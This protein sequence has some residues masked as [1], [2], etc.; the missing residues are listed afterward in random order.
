MEKLYKKST[1]FAPFVDALSDV[2][3][4]VPEQNKGRVIGILE[5]GSGTGGLTSKLLDQLK[6]MYEDMGSGTNIHVFSSSFLP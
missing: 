3:G 1:T 5:A 2:F 6:T 4:K